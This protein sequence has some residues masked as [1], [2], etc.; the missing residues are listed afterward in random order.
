MNIISYRT[1]QKKAAPKPAPS[2]QPLKT[3]PHSEAGSA[4]VEVSVH[5]VCFGAVAESSQLPKTT[6]HS[7]AGLVNTPDE[8]KTEHS[9][10]QNNVEVRVHFVRL[11]AGT[12]S[13]SCSE[14]LRDYRGPKLMFHF[15]FHCGYLRGFV[16][17]VQTIA[18]EHIKGAISFCGRQ[19][20]CLLKA[21]LS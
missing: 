9:G 11:A 12:H 19:S 3:T 15:P 13:N 20:R 10:A 16:V 17:A 7:E 8:T 21:L 5:F 1:S 4:N 6:P 14:E 2:S 18:A